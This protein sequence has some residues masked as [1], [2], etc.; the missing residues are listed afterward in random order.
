MKALKFWM[1]GILL[2][3]LTLFFASPYWVLHQINQA[4][5]QNNAA[6]ISKYIDFERVKASLK[7]QIQ[8]RMN[9]AT[10][11]EHLPPALQKW[12]HQLSS[13]LGDNV[14]DVVINEQT[15]LLLIQGKELKDAIRE[16]TWGAT[17]I[18]NPL[19]TYT[20]QLT[21][22]PQDDSLNNVIRGNQEHHQMKPKAHYIGWNRFEITVPTDSDKFTRVMMERAGVSWKI[23]EVLLPD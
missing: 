3:G 15:V 9:V 20:N 8:Q 22:A 2:L 18:S 16:N 13:V 6:G 10:G 21:T 23:T 17:E 11:I 4:Y 19:Q 5:Q 1:I 12:G 14:V 7:P